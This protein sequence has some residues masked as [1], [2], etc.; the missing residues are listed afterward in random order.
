MKKKVFFVF[1]LL[2]LALT[3]CPQKADQT[4]DAPVLFKKT[5]T[6]LDTLFLKDGTFL[7]TAP[8]GGEGGAVYW[9]NILDKP[10][11]FP[12]TV[13]SHDLLYKPIGY[14]PSWGEVTGK[15]TTFPPAAHTTA[16]AEIA[17][18]PELIELSEA[19]PQLDFLQPP[20]KTTAEI[21]ALV[22]PSGSEGAEIWD[23][24]L[25]VKK[26]WDGYLW[27]IIITDR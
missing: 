14:V 27:K 8:I 18:K 25:K 21:N 19:L 3:A 4:F 10:A 17:D 16:W 22:M 24:T 20:Q 6:L 13:H 11:L 5:V 2:A 26:M 1:A 7:L 15:P 23:K 12:P 9:N